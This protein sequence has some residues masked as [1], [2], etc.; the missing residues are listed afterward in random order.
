M[1]TTKLRIAAIGVLALGIVAFAVMR[2]HRSLT[3]APVPEARKAPKELLEKRRDAA[4]RVWEG[5]WRRMVTTVR[6]VQPSDLFGW[7]ER[8]LEAELALRDK[9]EERIAALKAH[10]DRTREL[11]RVAIRYAKMGVGDVADADAATYERIEAE[12]RYFQTAG[13][14][15]PP[16][17]KPLE[18][19]E[20]AK[21]SFLKK[22]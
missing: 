15:P 5:K 12:I 19:L 8:W 7:S 21:P 14:A 20:S 18:R 3:A 13:K 10:V 2:S 6:G 9:K 22:K 11:E 1:F 16:P 4:K 17:S